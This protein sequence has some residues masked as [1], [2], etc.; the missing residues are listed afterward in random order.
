MSYLDFETEGRKCIEIHSHLSTS[1]YDWAVAHTLFQQQVLCW[2]T[3]VAYYA[4]V[5]G[6]RTLFSLIEFDRKLQSKFRPNQ[7]K[8]QRLRAI[9]KFHS[10]FCSFLEDRDLNANDRVLRDTCIE[11]FKEHFPRVDWSLFI[12]RIGRILVAHKEARNAETYEHFV[13]AHHGRGYHFESPFLDTIF[14]ESEK[15]ANRYIAEI[16]SYVHQY[17]EREIPL[18]KYHLWHL[19][20][21]LWWLEKTLEKEK[22][23]MSNEMR[24]FLNLMKNLA[25]DMEKPVDYQDFENEMDMKYYTNKGEAYRK[26]REAAERLTHLKGIR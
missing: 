16:L 14:R 20:D 13:V 5:H 4:M 19:K 22:L 23:Q 12:S 11:C 25:K 21:E 9:A 3:T 24:V 10:Q 15:N 7:T 1:L 26:I 6:I 8:K 17:Y 2:S 18:R